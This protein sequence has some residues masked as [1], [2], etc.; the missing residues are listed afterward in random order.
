M[1]GKIKRRESEKIFVDI[2]P[3]REWSRFE[4]YDIFFEINRTG[5]QLQHNALDFIKKHRLF[6]ILI[7]NPMYHDQIVC[8]M[9]QPVIRQCANSKDSLNIEQEKAIESI[10]NG[11]YKPVPNLLYGPPGE[12]SLRVFELLS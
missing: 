5:Y 9:S 10:M 11:R 4:S 2:F 6:T 12:F 3:A 8:T 1:N 7:N